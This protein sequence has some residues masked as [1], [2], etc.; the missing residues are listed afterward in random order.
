MAAKLNR[1][2]HVVAIQKYIEAITHAEDMHSL[3]IEGPP[4]WGKTTSVEN[5]LQLSG[6]EGIG[7]GAY[8]TPLNL[9]NYLAENSSRIVLIDDCA[10]LFND[11]SAMA[12]L[13]AATWPSR[14]GRR[15]VKWG[16]TSHRASTL[17]FEFTGKLIIVCNAF[18]HTP[19]GEAIRSR[20]YTKR[21]DVTVQEAKRLL[22]Q[23]ASDSKWFSRSDIST[24]VAQFLV[25]RLSENNLS[26]MSFRTL[27]KGYRLA[28]VHEES[29]EEL[30]AD[31]IPEGSI[32]PEKLIK[33]LSKQKLKVKD[34]A[35]I[36]QEKT[37][38]KVRS[39]YNYRKEAKLSRNE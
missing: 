28:E 5:A 16:S 9:Y 14:D 19:D 39:F 30:F 10:G 1:L 11:Q 8:S 2:D 3:I 36:F 6:K 38:L 27:K 15:I 34:Q 26:H 18:P 37:G 17:E 33:D 32:Q 20:A 21:I 7:L 24:A 4:G 23:A 25:E 31:T 29:W 13:K 22:I 35:R 12:I